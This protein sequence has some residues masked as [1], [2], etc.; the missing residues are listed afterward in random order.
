[1]PPK[2][3]QAS[4][5]NSTTNINN[6]ANSQGQGSNVASSASNTTD[7]LGIQKSS[8][9]AVEEA[10]QNQDHSM[11]PTK[12]RRRSAHPPLASESQKD[13]SF[14][15]IQ[16]QN[17][18]QEQQ[19]DKQEQIQQQEYIQDS[20]KENTMIMNSTMSGKDQHAGH[21]SPSHSSHQIAITDNAANPNQASFSGITTTPTAT[22]VKETATAPK[23]SNRGRGRP[24]G[25]RGSNKPRGS[26]K[27]REPRL[28]LSDSYKIR[29]DNGFKDS[30]QWHRYF[31]NRNPNFNKASL[32]WEFGAL[33][34]LEDVL[35]PLQPRMMTKQGHSNS[36]P[37]SIAAEQA[38]NIHS[39]HQSRPKQGSTTESSDGSIVI[40]NIREQMSA[41]LIH[42]T[43]S[44]R[45]SREESPNIQDSDMDSQWDDSGSDS[46]DHNDIDSNSIDR[47][48]L[49]PGLI[50]NNGN[51]NNGPKSLNYSS[52]RKPRFKFPTPIP[53]L[54]YPYL[55]STFPYDSYSPP[56]EHDATKPDYG[57]HSQPLPD[58][59]HRPQG[60]PAIEDLFS[61]EKLNYS[62]KMI[63]K[64][65]VESNQLRMDLYYRRG[66]QLASK[67][68]LDRA[69]VAYYDK[70][71]RASRNIQTPKFINKTDEDK[72]WISKWSRKDANILRRNEIDGES[73]LLDQSTLLT[74][75]VAHPTVS[76]ASA[77]AESRSSDSFINLSQTT[78]EASSN[79]LQ[80]TTSNNDEQ[81]ERLIRDRLAYC[82]V[83]QFLAAMFSHKDD[84]SEVLELSPRACTI[85]QTLLSGL[86]SKLVAMGCKLQ[87]AELTERLA[88]IDTLLSTKTTQVN[89]ERWRNYQASRSHPGESSQLSPSFQTSKHM[90]GRD[91]EV[92]P[93]GNIDPADYYV[94][95]AAL[96]DFEEPF[97]TIAESNFT[98]PQ[99]HNQS[100]DENA[101]QMAESRD[102]NLPGP[103]TSSIVTSPSKSLTK[104]VSE[105]EL[106]SIANPLRIPDE[107][108]PFWRVRNYLEQ[109][110]VLSVPNTA[111][112]RHSEIGR[113]L[114]AQRTL[115]STGPSASKSVLMSTPMTPVITSASKPIVFQHVE[116]AV[117]T[118]NTQPSS[119]PSP[120]SAISTTA[121]APMS[122]IAIEIER[123]RIAQQELAQSSLGNSES[124]PDSTLPKE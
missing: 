6:V 101:E 79:A 77:T 92:Y 75:P 37:H 110:T 116:Q 118:A 103:S 84:I 57:R 43:A 32:T 102:Q 10:P 3:R 38:E 119:S 31:Q 51:T 48:S 41:V 2:R 81:A 121:P 27:S 99:N 107:M 11:P 58:L 12:K 63:K 97:V 91:K 34:P 49:S 7:V 90:A 60:G 113:L 59:W 21:D 53:P 86:E 111:D 23:S 104:T 62:I 114:Q 124:G 30:I 94:R 50:D 46:D 67:Q 18:Q 76:N 72:L 44:G 45:E 122:S 25:S 106:P 47:Q 100:E 29:S 35:P 55:H 42:D 4:S 14:I 56:K 70:Y 40:A 71:D 36:R 82:E 52:R 112:N 26:Y 28:S 8:S 73:V 19:Q 5:A 74:S 16:G 96:N 88:R 39:D 33:P 61:Q 120:S 95:T 98:T 89:R 109:K 15:T 108:D 115:A 54:E 22:F 24:R 87:R 68:A 123:L 13:S 93:T 64:Q 69:R 20:S 65:P 85:L 117:T 17:G 1:M 105:S 83:N 80:T 9:S 78:N 66:F